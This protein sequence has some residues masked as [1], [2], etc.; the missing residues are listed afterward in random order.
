MRG[1]FKSTAAH[2]GLAFLLVPLHNYLKNIDTVP[3]SKDMLAEEAVTATTSAA[4]PSA[5]VDF[6]AGTAGGIASLLAGHPFDTVKT[7]LQAQGSTAS[8]SALSSHDPSIDTARVSTSSSKLTSSPSARVDYS[9]TALSRQAATSSHSATLTLPHASIPSGGGSASIRVSLPVYRSAT[10]AFR[11]IIKEERLWGLYKGVTS[12]M[13]GV[14]IMNASIFGLYN[15]GLRYQQSHDLLSDHHIA[16]VFVAGMISGLGSSLITSPIDLI[17][18]REQMNT[19]SK[20]PSTFQV[21]QQVV[22]TEGI[23]RGL[24]RGWCTTAVRDL[25][26]G[27]Y[28]ASYELLNASIKAWTGRPLSNLDMAASGAVAGVVAWLS[29]FW[30]DVIKTKIQAST[31]LDDGGRRSL[32]WLTARETYRAGGV[33][34]FFVG[35][36]PTVLRALPVNAVLFVT[37]E[38]TKGFLISRGY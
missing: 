11:I 3:R 20:K 35:V 2:Q 37:Y 31:R 9:S 13:L 30:A 22:R 15:L 16:Q 36:G 28:F 18:I 34:A 1:C 4:G 7:R 25:G 26:Y 23:T 6:I 14:A 17:K 8:S 33:R 27:P 24:Y 12:P 38:V 19:S 21:F 32:F 5:M 10:D 29:T